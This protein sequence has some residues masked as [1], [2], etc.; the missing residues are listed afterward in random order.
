MEGN[1]SMKA[2]HFNEYILNEDINQVFE[3]L[4]PLSLQD[5]STIIERQFKVFWKSFKCH[6]NSTLVEGL[7]CEYPKERDILGEKK[8]LEI[9]QTPIHNY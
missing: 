4:Q 6:G 9:S 5:N 7:L 2:K 8:H 3:S 1:G